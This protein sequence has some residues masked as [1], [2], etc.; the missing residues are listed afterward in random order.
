MAQD[1]RFP[2]PA[3]DLRYRTTALSM[4]WVTKRRSMNWSV[5]LQ[6]N[7][8][9]NCRTRMSQQL[10]NYR[11]MRCI[12]QKNQGGDDVRIGRME[13]LNIGNPNFANIGMPTSFLFVDPRSSWIEP[14]VYGVREVTRILLGHGVVSYH[15]YTQLPRLDIGQQVEMQ[16]LYSRQARLW[17][18]IG[19]GEMTPK[20][21]LG[22]MDQ[23]HCG[24]M[25]PTGGFKNNI[26]LG[27]SVT[28]VDTPFNKMGINR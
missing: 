22:G 10:S 1:M 27:S 18:L 5:K 9:M 11:A 7:M 16:P 23:H 4:N 12:Q 26:S 25:V 6:S 2:T 20:F 13:T 17:R 24:S 15:N 14:L 8:H 28:A 19:E 3:L 21:T